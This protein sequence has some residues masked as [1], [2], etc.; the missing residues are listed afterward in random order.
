MSLKAKLKALLPSVPQNADELRVT[1]S[2]AA[3]L[4]YEIEQAEA[5][6]E[7]AVEEAKRPFD[8]RIIAAEKRLAGLL[9]ALKTWA[10]GHRDEFAGRQSYTI[11]GHSLT[12]RRSQGK[13]D[14]AASDTEAV[15]AILATDDDALIDLCLTV[16]PALDKKAIKAALEGPDA[17]LAQ[18]LA[19]I[20]FHIDRPE[21]FKFEPARV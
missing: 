12:F 17:I 4:T 7:T 2:E 18:R 21:E 10:L 1:V 6:R 16:K 13:L 19:D 5:Q 15:E 3:R 11:A 8:A 20:G 14:N 9:A